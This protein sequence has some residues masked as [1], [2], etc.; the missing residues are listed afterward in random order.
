VPATIVEW[1]TAELQDAG[2]LLRWQTSREVNTQSFAIHRLPLGQAGSFVPLAGAVASQGSSGGSYSLWDDQV[3][4]DSLYSYLLV[5]EK[6]NGRFVAYYDLVVVM[7]SAND[8]SH[9]V[10]LPLMLH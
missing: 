3:D 2:I 7:V 1:F 5:E 8:S 4:T 6:D 10:L 9:Q